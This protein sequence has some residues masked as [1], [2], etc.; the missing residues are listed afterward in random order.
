MG[1]GSSPVGFAPQAPAASSSGWHYPLQ[2]SP[3][4]PNDPA[5]DGLIELV[6]QAASRRDQGDS[7]WSNWLWS[8]VGNL[9]FSR[10][11]SLDLV[12]VASKHGFDQA[13]PSAAQPPKL[14]ALMGDLEKMKGATAS[15][16]GGT[17]GF[18]QKTA[19]FNANLGQEMKRAGP[20]IYYSMLEGNVSARDWLQSYF[21]GNKRSQQWTDLW[22]AAAIVDFEM[23]TAVATSKEAV[24]EILE[25]N[26]VVEINL[27]RLAAYVYASRTGDY[28]GAN[29]MLALRAP[30]SACDIAPS[31]LVTEAT[32]FS[33]AEYQRT[34]RVS[35]LAKVDSKGKGKGK[36]KKGKDGPGPAGSP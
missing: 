35:H 22:H 32:S 6:R 30:G 29:H 4:A 13:N 31:W 7:W 9:C 3:A 27:R 18:G 2:A 25:S 15:A 17:G 14:E 24:D 21:Q 5:I 8:Q 16:L 12:K 11:L 1:L 33:K 20:E 23:A 34:E 10:S 26:E 36:G 19:R 28:S